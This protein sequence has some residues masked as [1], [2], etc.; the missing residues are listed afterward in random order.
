MILMRNAFLAGV[1]ALAC[2]A[3][4]T[5]APPDGGGAATALSVPDNAR[6]AGAGVAIDTAFDAGALASC[7]IDAAGKITITIA[8]E[9]APPINC[10][11][12]YAFRL[13]SAQAR[14]V[15]IILRYEAC[16]HRYWPKISSNGIDWQYLPKKAIS[17]SAFAGREQAKITVRT[18]GTPVF[19]AAQEIIV[20]ATYNAWLD[21]LER[22]SEV[23]RSLLGKS[24][25][26]RDIEMIRFGNRNAREQVVL[27]GRQHPPEVSGALAMF[28]F[29]ETLLGD[30]PLARQFRERFQVTAVPLV[31]PDGV[32]LGHWRHSTGGLDLNRDW[33]D[34]SQPETQLL[35]GLLRAIAANPDQQL[36]FF[37]D[38]HSTAKDVFYTIPDRF[39]STPPKVISTW[40]ERYQARMPGY[41]VTIEANHS[42]GS[43]VSKGSVYDSYGA[44]TV[45]F[46]LGDE[47]DRELIKRIGRESAIAMMEVL[48]AT[49]QGE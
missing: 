28:P 33:L 31:N 2:S 46:E 41:K 14:E 19:V 32:V 18:S 23:T 11:P 17:I 45:T 48:L 16:G 8:P 26:D 30:D 12:W 6:C 5:T 13:H 7:T 38:F 15:E 40:L 9:D 25:Q 3:C 37:S 22:K 42:P 36:S 4:A 35:N 20:P 29:V 27:I 1:L 39:P 47:T 43:N 49:D 10:S 21:G 44:P 24:A 34:F